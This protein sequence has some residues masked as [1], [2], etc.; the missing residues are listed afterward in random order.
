MDRVIRSLRG[1]TTL[2]ELSLRG[3][4][5]RSLC[6]SAIKDVLVGRKGD[7]SHSLQG[8]EV[9][10]AGEGGGLTKLAT[11]RQSFLKSKPRK[12]SNVRVS[13]FLKGLPAGR[14]LVN[15]PTGERK[16][17]NV[18]VSAA[19]ES[20]YSQPSFA[21]KESSHP[22]PRSYLRRLDLSWNSLNDDACSYLQIGLK[23]CRCLEQLDLSWNLIGDRGIVKVRI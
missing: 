13:T 20:L 9:G 12:V 15:T 10:A 7:R 5:I 4:Q 11:L 16:A 17:S 18:A 22:F 1:N 19:V 2:T 23:H 21:R 6:A 3:N 8:K 14:S